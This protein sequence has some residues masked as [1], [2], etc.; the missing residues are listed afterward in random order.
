MIRVL[1]VD[2][3]RIGEPKGERKQEREKER[4]NDRKSFSF[5]GDPM[6]V[7]KVENGATSIRKRI[8]RQR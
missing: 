8:W 6:Y 3:N 7:V 5:K 2:T 1:Y 4:K